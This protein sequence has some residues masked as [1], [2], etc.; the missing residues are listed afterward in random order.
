MS[1][2]I[3]RTNYNNRFPNNKLR[4]SRSNHKFNQYSLIIWVI[5]LNK[6]SLKVWISLYVDDFLG[7]GMGI[8][9]GV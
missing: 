4:S 2:L 1:N 3:F 5:H 7:V 8:G 6:I 9:L